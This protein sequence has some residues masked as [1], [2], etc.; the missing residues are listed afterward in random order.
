MDYLLFTYPNCS[1]CEKMK[2]ALAELKI[3]YEEYNLMQPQAKARIRDFVKALKRDEKGAVILPTLILNDQGIIRA[4][5]NNP[6]EVEAWWKS[7]A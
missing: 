2:T 3:P 5:M 1:R 4:L 6:E 7:K